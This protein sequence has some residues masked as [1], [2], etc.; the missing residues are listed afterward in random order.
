MTAGGQP[1]AHRRIRA[2]REHGQA[3]V[4]P[5]RSQFADVLQ[6]N[7]QLTYLKVPQRRGLADGF[8]AQAR[9]ELVAAAFAYTQQY[10]DVGEMPDPA[11]PILM[12][13]HQPELFHAG[14]WF[15]S[16]LLSSLAEESRS[17]AIN[18]IVDNDT[19][20]NPAI[21]VPT[22]SRQ[23]PHVETVVLDTAADEMPYEQRG[24]IDVALFDSFAQ[25]VSEALGPWISDPLMI[26]L[27]QY[28][29]DAR[30]ETSNLGQT[31]ARARHVLEEKLGLRTLEVPLSVVAAQPSFRA[32]ALARLWNADHLQR[33]Y[34][35]VLQEY[36]QVNHIRSRAHPVPDLA[37]D[38]EWCETPFWIWTNEQPLRKRLFTRHFA[39]SLQLSDRHSLTLELPED[40]DAQLEVWTQWE[41]GGIKIRP[42]ALMTTMYARLF[43]CD[44]FIHGIGGAKYDEVTDA[45]I[46]RS[47]KIE[48]PH[49]LTAT[50]TV[51]L[52]LDF[53][54]TSAAELQAAQ[55]EAHELKYR[56]EHYVNDGVAQALIEAK[57]ALLQQI[58]PRGEKLHWH[59]AITQVNGELHRL[60]ASKQQRLDDRVAQLTE[61]Q[62]LTRLL[63][64]REFSFALFPAEFLR[65]LLLDLCRAAP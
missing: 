36:R 20:D 51:Q 30:R 7:R 40:E 60:V 53:P 22:G 12:A 45:I 42:R 64:S 39:R 1:I 18:L 59:D 26:E 13:G 43:L 49:Y 33:D 15:K 10:R 4:D 5:P 28:A 25:R 17:I 16:F 46:R 58:P 62:R 37:M 27:W 11:A 34:N 55:H 61:Q 23:S 19:V 3:L 2:P 6:A 32:F 65:T 24:I 35:G 57:H 47:M 44:L 38:G 63:G 54:R 52:P 41:Q 50:A 14:V 21:R 8:T 31:I 29:T 48:P 56:A 9:R